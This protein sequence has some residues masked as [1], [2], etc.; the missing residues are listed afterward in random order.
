MGRFGL[1]PLLAALILTTE[2]GFGHPLMAGLGDETE[3]QW[4]NPAIRPIRQTAT[5]PSSQ[6]DGRPSVVH[7]PLGV[8]IG[9]IAMVVLPDRSPVYAAATGDWS[10]IDLSKTLVQ[11]R[12]PDLNDRKTYRCG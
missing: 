5:T 2:L 4:G 9:L 12:H 3:I 10:E 1:L 11:A 6:S 8:P 7:P